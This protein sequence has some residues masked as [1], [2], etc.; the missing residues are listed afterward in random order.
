V[1]DIA[2]QV[3]HARPKDDVAWIHM[4][5]YNNNQLNDGYR[6]QFLRYH[7]PSEPYLY[8]VNRKGKIAAIL[9]GAFSADELEK[10]VNAAAK[11]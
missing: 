6:P 4:E 1:V 2:E 10:A 5:I 3:R 7:L 9:E 11:G 8:T